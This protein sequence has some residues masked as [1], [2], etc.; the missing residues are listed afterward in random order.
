MSG[1]SLVLW[2]KAMSRFLPRMLFLG[3][4]GRGVY[5]GV[6]SSTV[7]SQSWINEALLI[8]DGKHGLF[9]L[10]VYLEALH[11]RSLE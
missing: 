5:F 6:L 8:P 1:I 10:W 2:A 7:V 3:G 4:R 9:A 11:L